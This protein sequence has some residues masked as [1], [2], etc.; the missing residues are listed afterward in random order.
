MH[1]L[2]LGN[3]KVDRIVRS[4]VRACVIGNLNSDPMLFHDDAKF[5][6]IKLMDY[7]LSWHQS[8]LASM[9]GGVRVVLLRGPLAQCESLIRSGLTVSEACRWYNDV[10]HRMS[11]ILNFPDTYSIRF[12]DLLLRPKPVLEDLFAELEISLP[13]NFVAKSK[14][15]GNARRGNVNVSSAPMVSIPRDSLSGFLDAENEAKAVMRLD[16]NSR[17][18][19]LEKTRNAAAGLGYS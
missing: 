2:G 15:F 18:Q 1:E 5:A 6:A 14:P 12:E 9:D 16:R 3:R 10:A 4:H 13:D 8:V 17:D 19:I 11:L 7:F